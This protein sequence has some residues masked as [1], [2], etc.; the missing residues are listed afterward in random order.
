[1]QKI[2][3]KMIWVISILILASLA[4]SMLTN[5]NQ[6]QQ[7]VQSVSTQIQGVATQAPGLIATARAIATE[8]PGL[9]QTGQALITTQGPGLMKTLQAFATANPSLAQTAIAMVTQ[10]SKGGNPDSA[11]SDIPLLP[12]DRLEQYNGTPGMVVFFTN[13]KYSKVVSFYKTEMV[14]NSWVPVEKGTV[15]ASSSTVLNF[16]KD[17]RTSSVLITYNPGDSMTG[18]VITIQTK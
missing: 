8:N 1:M 16:S 11:P 9:I 13:M 2:P 10:A 4:C 17:K 5:V 15:E 12:Q 7:D 6:F 3:F 14:K 18:V